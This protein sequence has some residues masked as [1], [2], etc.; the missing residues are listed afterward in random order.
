MR[1]VVMR[2]FGDP[3]VLEL[4]KIPRPEPGPGEAR[5][6]VEA[7]A[8][9]NTRDV[10]TRTGRHPFSSSVTPPHI[11]GGEHAGTVD[12]LGEGVEAGW[13]GRRV[14]VAAAIPCGRCPFCLA[15]HDEACVRSEV[16][17]IHRPGAYAE[18]VTVPMTNVH[19]LPDDVS[20]VDAAVLMTTGPV[21]LAQVNA[22]E[23]GEGDVLVVPGI[24][25]ALGSM[26]AALAARRGVR[27]VGLERDVQRLASLALPAA[28][29]LDATA[30]NLEDQL[31]D[32]CGAGGAQ[33]VI[34]NLGLRHIWDA[35]LAVLGPRGRVVI[36]GA[37]GDGPVSVHLRRLYV[38]S[39]S[40]I[41]LR[42]GNLRAVAEFWSEVQKG[43]RLPGGLVESFALWNAAGVHGG[44][45]AGQK[46]GHYA[47][48]TESG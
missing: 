18:F 20:S 4:Q 7:V 38:G 37:I 25:G 16:I 46:V 15:G 36:S 26:V 8:L 31:R 35:C 43:F 44:V 21:G 10:L 33:A 48:T 41:G 45:E 29:I 42:T 47:L 9:N 22:A 28:E 1:A 2:D 14:A 34:D 23:L 24:G 3:G 17:G 5:I 40:I 13:L 27:V 39:Q 32:A 30:E 6:R 19:R 12:A 11:L